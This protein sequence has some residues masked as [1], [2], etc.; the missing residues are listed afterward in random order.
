MRFSAANIYTKVASFVLTPLL[1]SSD[2]LL[3]LP[4]VC[5]SETIN[6]VFLKLFNGGII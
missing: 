3:P 1:S 6:A 5:M 2:E 4:P